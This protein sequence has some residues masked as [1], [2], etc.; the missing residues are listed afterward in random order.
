MTMRIR[1]RSLRRKT[2]KPKLRMIPA[3]LM[4]G[5]LTTCVVFLGPRVIAQDAPQDVRSSLE[6]RGIEFRDENFLRYAASGD[7][8]ILKLFLDAGIEI[9]SKNAQGKTA[10]Q[11]ATE[12]NQW[13]AAALLLEHGAESL[14]ALKALRRK[15]WGREV[16]DTLRDVVS[17][18]GLL[19]AFVGSL[20]TWVYN[21]SQQRL[22]AQRNAESQRLQLLEA[23]EKMIPH[24]RGRPAK[25]R[26]LRSRSWR[27]R[28]SW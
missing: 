24:L 28:T 15:S 13:E 19:I 2:T 9:E 18:P 23:T 11:L 21:K 27:A 12:Q 3:A 16:F 7:T 25:Q 26:S 22:A 1:S 10:L 5:L 17:N 4:I 20:F 8:E 6:A 14:L